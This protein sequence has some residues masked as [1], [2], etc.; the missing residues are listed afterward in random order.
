MQ[1]EQAHGSL[2][3]LPS[4]LLIKKVRVP[5]QVLLYFLA[6]LLLRA[7]LGLEERTQES[8]HIDGRESCG[9]LLL[10]GGQNFFLFD[11]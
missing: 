2:A 6:I 7:R 1:A 10:G 9:Y 11:C 4:E 3:I 5:N 8:T